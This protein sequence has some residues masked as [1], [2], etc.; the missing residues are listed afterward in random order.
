M[1]VSELRAR[2]VEAFDAGVR[3]ADPRRGVVE[4]LELTA[5]GRPVIAGSV[6]EA[7]SDLRVVAFGKAGV[8]MARTVAEILPPEIFVGPGVVAVHAEGFAEIDRFR[9]FA[10]GHPVPD[11]VGVSA[12]AA[13]GEYLSDGRDGDAVLTLISGGGSAL[14]PA[15]APGIS[16]QDKMETT[17]LL[18]AS[19][20]PIQEI[21]CVRKH[22]SVLKGGGLAR[23][24]SPA[25]IESLI[26]SDVIGDDLSSIAS[27]P[28]A[29]DPTSFAD[30]A[31]ILERYGLLGAVPSAVAR[32]LD[33]GLAGELP[34]TPTAGD[35]LFDRVS[36]RLVGSN[37]QSL[38]A[39]CEQIED[40][41]FVPHVVSRTLTGEARQAA[42]RLAAEAK[43]RWTGEGSLAI[44]AGGETTVTLRG[45][46]RGGRNQE[47]ALAFA[48]AAEELS[49][50]GDWVFLSGG[51]DG[52][53]GPT[54]A[55][56]GL[57]DGGTLRR[58]CEVGLEPGRELDRN[59]S[60]E[61]L[62]AAGDLVITGATGTNVADLQIVLL[63]A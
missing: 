47:M 3:A 5:A 34:E 25:R 41:G 22:L 58:I 61:A 54:D 26:L 11:A 57:V 53:D 30:A 9:V 35:P 52:R 62:R 23:V 28:T 50:G 24:A 4:H 59:N 13:V 42:N 6:L 39:A 37:E 12:A 44:L 48:M 43:R 7:G 32:R 33:D 49:L 10:A 55:A 38:E 46:G 40:L 21:N 19:G 20:A 1:N 29:P 18:L 31:E 16:L 45:D 60:H 15:P 27:G 51:T 63:R 17:R 14:L 2:A 8:S 56:G 36:N